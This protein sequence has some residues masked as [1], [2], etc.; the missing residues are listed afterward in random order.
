MGDIYEAVV[1]LFLDDEIDAI[2]MR[3]LFQLSQDQAVFLYDLLSG[4]AQK[5]SFF[6]HCSGMPLS[7]ALSYLLPKVPSFEFGDLG[8]DVSVPFDLCVLK[9]II[10]LFVT[11][12]IVRLFLDPRFD[13]HVF[14]FFDQ[15]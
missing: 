5:M 15:A 9:V 10:R 3:K 6:R 12:V 11:K 4:F 1:A 2:A 8:F 7:S 14:G 13:F